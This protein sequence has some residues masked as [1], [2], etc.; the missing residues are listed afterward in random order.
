[1][2]MTDPIA[3]ML[4]RVR[5]AAMVRKA[6]VLVPYS[7]IKFAIAKILEKENYIIKAEG[8]EEKFPMIKI[9]LK[10]DGKKSAI[11]KLSRASK[12][13]RRQYVRKVD[14]PRVLNGYGLAIV[15]TSKGVMTNKE[16]KHVG[17]GGEV[18]CEIY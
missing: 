18:I 12:V 11:T 13:G 3:D 8:V 16:A 1:M 4:T 10:Y 14:M 6:E 2:S 15:S 5:N 7:R 9:A 17:I